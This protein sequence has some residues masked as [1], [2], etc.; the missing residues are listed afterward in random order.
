LF[1]SLHNSFKIRRIIKIEDGIA[2]GYQ[3]TTGIT[4]FATA[5]GTGK[6]NRRLSIKMDP[7]PAMDLPVTTPFS[8]YTRYAITSILSVPGFQVS[9]TS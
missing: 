2:D 4:A 8:S 5:L 9:R 7:F 3:K 1:G 6:N